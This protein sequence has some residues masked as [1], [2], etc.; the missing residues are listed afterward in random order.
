MGYTTVGQKS[1]KVPTS[2][3]RGGFTGRPLLVSPVET[4]VNF[5]PATEVA[6]SIIY[7]FFFFSL[8]LH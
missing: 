1:I 8:E 5:I 4:I 6:V 2:D 3:G 7:L